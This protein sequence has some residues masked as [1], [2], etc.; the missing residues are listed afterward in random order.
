[1][2]NSTSKDIPFSVWN[3][4]KLVLS[5]ALVILTCVDLGLA[6]K[7]SGS[8]DMIYPVHY[9]TPIIK[10]ATFVSVISLCNKKKN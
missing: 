5:V 10:I 8:D 7:Y 6:I 2:R 1:M 4:S 9:Y 3:V